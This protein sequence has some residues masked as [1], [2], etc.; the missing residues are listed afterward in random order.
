MKIRVKEKCRAC[1]GYGYIANPVNEEP[2]GTC[3]EIGFE[4][5]RECNC[6]GYIIYY[7]EEQ[8]K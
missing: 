4:P 8:S 5:C 6:E 1:D 7:R 2:D 3:E